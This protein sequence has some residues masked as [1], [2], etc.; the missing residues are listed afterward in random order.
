M[1]ED[2][3]QNKKTIMPL[4]PFRIDI[5]SLRL[6]CYE[7]ANY[8]LGKLLVRKYDGQILKGRIIETEAYLGGEDRASHSYGGR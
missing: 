5:E 4:N 3:N 1:T 2:N 7:M 6:P 8:L